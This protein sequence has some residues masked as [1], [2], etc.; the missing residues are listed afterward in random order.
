MVGLVIRIFSFVFHILLG[1]AMMAISLVAWTSGQ[2]TLQIGFLPWQGL[3]LTC[4]LS[5]FGLLAVIVTLL[6]IKRI[7]PV[8]FLVWSLAVLVLLVRGY[9]FSSYTFARGG[10]LG[11]VCFV[12]AALLA[13]LGSLAQL[14]QRRPAE[15]RRTAEA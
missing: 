9:F 8:L 3:G 2:H 7:V 15:F 1:L 6:A 13:V 12:A 14:R 10:F 5:G 4:L 11:A